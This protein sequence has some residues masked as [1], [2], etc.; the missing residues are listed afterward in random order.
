MVSFCITPCQYY[1]HKLVGETR[2]MSI[3]GC[4]YREIVKV[5][6]VGIVV[7]NSVVNRI[8]RLAPK[9]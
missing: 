9:A 6:V 5:M 8:K 7:A 1:P 2:G 3:R 4:L